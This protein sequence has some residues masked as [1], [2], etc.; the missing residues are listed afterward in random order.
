MNEMRNAGRTKGAFSWLA[1]FS[2][3]LCFCSLSIPAFSQTTIS[4]GSIQGTITDPTGAVVPHATVTITNKATG[5]KRVLVATATGAY[6]SGA[7]IPGD[8]TVRV[9][10][11]GFKTTELSIT[12]QVGVTSAGNVK[13]QVG[14]AST[15][16]SVTGT[17]VAVNTEQAT[18]QNVLTRSQISNL[19]I[20][21]RN[22]LDL[23]QLT[24][25]VQMQDGT[26]FDPTKVGFSSISIAGQFG[27][28]A[29]IEVDGVDVSDETVGTV[30]ENI[31][32]SAIQEFSI[33]QSTLDPSTEL[34]SSGAVN[35]VTRHGTNQYHGDAFGLFRD[36]STNASLPGTPGLAAPYSRSQF[37]GDVGGPIIHNKLFFFGDAERTVQAQVAPVAVAAPFGSYGGTVSAPYREGDLLGR[38]DYIGPHGLRMFYRF[39]YFKN[40]AVSTS[41]VSFS[42]FKDVNQTRQHV[43]GADFATGNFTHSFRFS[44]LKFQNN[45]TDAV[46]GSALPFANY[47]VS[48]Q[49][50][51]TGLETGP[52]LLAP[53]ETPQSD[54]Q[55]KYDGSWIH[56]NHIIRYGVDFNHIQ[57]GGYADFFGLTPTVFTF[58]GFG[59]VS[60][61]C[62]SS[63]PTCYPIFLALVGNNQ[64]FSTEQPAFGLPGGGLGPD[65]RLGVYIGDSWRT[66]PNLTLSAGLRWDRDTGRTDSD[67]NTL[68][69][70]NTYLP[71]MGNPVEQANTNLAPQVGLAW[72]PTGS[73]KTSIRIGAGLFFE[74][75]I[76]NNVLFDRPLRLPAGSFLQFPTA[77]FNGTA[78][79]VPFGATGPYAGQS[80]TVDQVMGTSGVCGGSIGQAATTLNA[81]EKIYQQSW[82]IPKALPNP[83]YAPSL[84]SQGLNVPTGLFAPGYK[85]PVSFQFNAGIQRQLKPGLV[86]SV[87]YLRNVNTHYLLSIDANHAGDVAY[88]NA[89]SAQDAIAATNASYNCGDS[90]SQSSIDCA[91]AAGASMEDYAANGL[92]SAVDAGGACQSPEVLGTPWPCAFSGRNPNVGVVP[93]LFP[94]GRSVYNAMMIKL[95]G[96]MNHVAP[97][98]HALNLQAGYTLSKFINSGAT[99][100]AFV[101]SALNQ[102]DPLAYS[103]YSSLDRT[104]MFSFGGYADVPAGFRLGFIGHFFSPLPLTLTVPPGS[105]GYSQMF[106]T[107]FSGTG[108]DAVSNAALLPG[109]TSGAFGRTISPGSVNTVINA[110][111]NTAA[112]AGCP[113]GM[114]GAN[115]PTPAGQTLI[116]SGL[117]NLGELQALGGVSPLVPPAPAGQNGLGWMKEVDFTLSWHYAI[118]EKVTV[119]PSVSLYN[120]FNFANFDL[121]G[122]S[123]SGALTG[124]ACS[125]NG[126][127]HGSNPALDCPTDRVGLGTGVFGT[128]APRQLEFGLKLS[129]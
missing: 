47:P 58:A 82:S 75:V 121:P 65:N 57:G 91:I 67:L 84:V 73:G 107:D 61:S 118:D 19:P 63:D 41:G 110:Y 112:A 37:G 102:R 76:Y 96:N 11:K 45:L 105:G 101:N 93:F 99:D 87:N 1:L 117:F 4:T 55:F 92:T 119:E 98:I 64:G 125:A 123:I 126:T 122:E 70:I 86:L 120:A 31:P 108:V 24:P 2:F 106:Q 14:A 54:H 79:P 26:N 66:M 27:R 36:S 48:M 34:T 116:S 42:P 85:T 17:T 56:G 59:S 6:S 103:G 46:L 33:E 49:F 95:T 80:L 90:Y 127:V 97:G 5:Q 25:G 78:L 9:D 104:D 113:A 100:Q 124:S 30:T 60:S 74:N 111:D 23:A 18:V 28:T 72:D 81:F 43:I 69:A 77:C 13:L 21:G 44:Y 62:P 12:V 20:N 83:S 68:Q 35:I 128:G 8:Y 114:L 71:G 109:T 129:F 15:V 89:S 40:I 29:R 22:F 10:A 32:Q 94:V 7:L 50:L 38:I 51:D 88:F 3:L 16:V 52:N 115:C 39:S 53:Q